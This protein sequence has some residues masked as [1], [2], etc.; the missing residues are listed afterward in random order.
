MVELIFCGGGNARFAQIAIDAGFLYGSQLPETV[1]FPLYFADQDWRRPNRNAYM[2]ALEKHRPHM[3]SV[4]DLERDDQL[5]EVL[6][7]AEEAAQFVSVVMLIPKA[8]GIIDRLS[9]QIGGAAVRLGY[10][11]PTKHGGTSVPAW[12]FSGW[13]VHLLGGSPQSQIRHAHYMHVVSADGN[14][15]AK[16]A[17]NHCVFFDPDRKVKKLYPSILEFDGCHYENDAPYEAWRRSCVN[18]MRLWDRYG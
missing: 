10:S 2:K 18:I 3:A 9:R 16:L 12:E 4:L 8:I 5:N 15:M 13:P 6:S 11:I 7:W 14:M 17:R 1:Y